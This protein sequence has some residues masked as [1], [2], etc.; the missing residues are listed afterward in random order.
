[1]DISRTQ[2]KGNTCRRRLYLRNGE[3]KLD[4]EQLMSVLKKC[5]LGMSV[6]MSHAVATFKGTTDSIT[7]LYPV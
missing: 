4:R 2:R 1:V 5:R 7:N 6:I 3:N